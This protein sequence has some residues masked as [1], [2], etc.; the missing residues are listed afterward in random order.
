MRESVLT[1][2][3]SGSAPDVLVARP[4]RPEDAE[5]I[6]LL[7]APFVERGLLVARAQAELAARSQ[8]FV[9]A[10]EGDRLVGC[11]GVA[12]AGDSLVVY[13][14]CIAA[15]RQG[16][17]IGRDLV[18]MAESTARRLGCSALLALTRHGGKWFG[19]LGFTEVPAN[20]TRDE[21]RALFR[22]G[23]KSSLY[24]LSLTSEQSGNRSTPACRLKQTKE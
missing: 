6:A 17:G 16:R 3:R 23:R 9:V 11:A 7:S 12:P 10:C 22:P 2:S 4:A 19:Q 14:L 13:N 5:Q 24:R 1:A 8:D 18:G 20:E 21:W 15:D